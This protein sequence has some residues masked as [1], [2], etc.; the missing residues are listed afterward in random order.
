M[1]FSLQGHPNYRRY[2]TE[3]L[4]AAI[5]SSGLKEQLWQLPG[6]EECTEVLYVCRDRPEYT[7]ETRDTQHAAHPVKA[8]GQQ[9][10]Q[11]EERES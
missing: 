1:A 5:R 2:R 7:G 6:R 9:T 8:L 4:P 10:T 11:R 3:P